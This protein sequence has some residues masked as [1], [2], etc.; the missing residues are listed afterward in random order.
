MNN[1][2]EQELIDLDKAWREIWVKREDRWQIVVS[3][4]TRLMEP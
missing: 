4:K 3:Q 2:I 1:P